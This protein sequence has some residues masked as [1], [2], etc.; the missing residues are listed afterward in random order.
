MTTI[1]DLHLTVYNLNEALY[2]YSM[3]PTKAESKR[4][5]LALGRIKNSTPALRKL[6]VAA[7]MDGN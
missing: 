5:R 1:E 7:D 6:L 4:I 3:K 2:K